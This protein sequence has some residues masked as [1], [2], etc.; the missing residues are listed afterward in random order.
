MFVCVSKPLMVV[1]VFFKTFAAAK[2][3]LFSHICKKKKNFF[4]NNSV[5]S[6]KLVI[7]SANKFAYI[8][9]KLYICSQ[10]VAKS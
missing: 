5:F 10:N 9:K 2:V 4:E 1:C 8:R 3:L 7:K 6:P